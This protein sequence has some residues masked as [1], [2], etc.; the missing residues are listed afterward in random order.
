MVVNINGVPSKRTCYFEVAFSIGDASGNH[1]L[2]GH[3]VNFVGNVSRKQRECNIPHLQSDNVNYACQL[4]VEHNKI[5]DVVVKCVNAIKAKENV[6]H[7]RETLKDISQNAVIP[8]HFHLSY[9]ENSGGI[10]TCR[11][12][13][14]LN[15][16]GSFPIPSEKEVVHMFHVHSA[17]LC[18]A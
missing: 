6:S 1:K 12:S 10:H 7:N 5:Q 16:A 15:S 3:Y 17:C 18:C 9:G 13:S 4:N 14:L 11:C 2:C 8:A